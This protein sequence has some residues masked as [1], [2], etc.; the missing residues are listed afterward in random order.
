MQGISEPAF[1]VDRSDEIGL[2]TERLSAKGNGIR[3]GTEIA[4]ELQIGEP[5]RSGDIAAGN[6]ADGIVMHTRP[7]PRED[8]VLRRDHVG[9]DPRTGGPGRWEAERLDAIGVRR[10]RAV[11]IERLGGLVPSDPRSISRG[12]SHCAPSFEASE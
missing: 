4:H 11:S 2:I 12:R 6:G 8:S 5:A 7:L 9:V 1:N 3:A 10:G